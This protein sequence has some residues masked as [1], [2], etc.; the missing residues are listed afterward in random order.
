MKPIDQL[1]FG[2]TRNVVEDGEGGYLLMVTPP[3]LLGPKPT[4][5]INLTTDQYHRY[6]LWRDTGVLIQNALPELSN[7]ER[8]LIMTGLSDQDFHN[9]ARSEEDGI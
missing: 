6:L 7:S 5:T 3:K 1:G 2:P 9:V 8:E 4:M